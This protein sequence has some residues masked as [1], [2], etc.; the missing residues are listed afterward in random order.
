MK[1]HEDAVRR[2]AHIDFHEIGFEFDPSLNR[3]QCV[4][5]SMSGSATMSDSQHMMHEISETT[6]EGAGAWG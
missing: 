6:A 1:S 2:A 4:F 3:G 5:R